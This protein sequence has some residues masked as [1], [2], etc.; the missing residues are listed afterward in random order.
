MGQ[1]KNDLIE[2]DTMGNVIALKQ[3]STKK[4]LKESMKNLFMYIKG[5]M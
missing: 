3:W 2:I 1:A 5:E 4:D